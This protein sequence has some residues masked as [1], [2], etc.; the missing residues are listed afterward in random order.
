VVYICGVFIFA[1][2]SRRRAAGV[3]AFLVA[4]ALA[5]AVIGCGSGGD[6]PTETTGATAG[7]PDRQGSTDA[8]STAAQPSERGQAKGADADKD[9]SGS[10]GDAQRGGNGASVAATPGEPVPAGTGKSQGPEGGQGQAVSTGGQRSIERVAAKHCPKG[11]DL[12]QCKALVEGSKQTHGTPSYPVTEP[13]D[14]V[15]AMGQAECEAVYKAQKEAA[16]A[17]GESVDVQKCLQNPTPRCEAILRPV[18]EQQRAAEEAS[19]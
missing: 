18:F 6:S 4:A 12:S 15:K 19:K 5:A 1:R 10:A 2:R 11:L 9:G 3:S 17:G 13:D 14:C 7:S 8:G 16:E